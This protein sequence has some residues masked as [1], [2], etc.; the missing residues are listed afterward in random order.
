MSAGEWSIRPHTSIIYMAG[1]S[2]L[3]FAIERRRGKSPRAPVPARSLGVTLKIDELPGAIGNTLRLPPW[4]WLNEN[5]RLRNAQSLDCVGA[6]R[7]TS[8]EV[9]CGEP[10]KDQRRRG[11][12]HDPGARRC[13]TGHS[14]RQKPQ[15]GCA[16]YYAEGG[17]D[18]YAA[19]DSPQH[20]PHQI[21]RACTKR[22]ANSQFTGALFHDIPRHAVDPYRGQD[23]RDATERREKDGR[24]PFGSER[25][26][27]Q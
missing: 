4:F 25:V 16:A 20:Q 6:R 21:A 23:Q 14:G 1:R 10:H 5:D 13:D 2:R 26:A 12:Q 9:R 19:R 27:S 17:T 8:W 11:E 18:G 24:Q 3:V 22:G 7:T 15:T